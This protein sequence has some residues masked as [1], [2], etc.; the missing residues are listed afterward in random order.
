VPAA[1]SGSAGRISPR[2]VHVPPYIA[3]QVQLRS[4][5]GRAYG[6]RIAGTL[7]RTGAGRRTD[8]ALLSGLRP[9]K[10]LS[11]TPVGGGS[12]VRIVADAEPG[13]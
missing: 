10:S 5:D 4:S 11:G 9:G 8:S 6:L 7:L 2:V 13:P 12:P 3:V 1:F